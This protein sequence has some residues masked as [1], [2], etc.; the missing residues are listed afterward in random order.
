MMPFRALYGVLRA[1]LI[2]DVR[3]MNKEGQSTH[4]QALGARRCRVIMD[5]TR[6]CMDLLAD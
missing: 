6:H 5:S 4:S 3:I 1:G 2:P